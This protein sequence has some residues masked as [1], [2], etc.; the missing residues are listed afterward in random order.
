MFIWWQQYY[1]MMKHNSAR[2]VFLWFR[3]KYKS[4]KFLL[5]YDNNRSNIKFD[6]ETLSYIACKSQENTFP[7]VGICFCRM[8]S[9]LLHYCSKEDTLLF[10]FDCCPFLQSILCILLMMVSWCFNVAKCY[11]MSYFINSQRSASL[12]Y[13]KG[14]TCVTLP[15]PFVLPSLKRTLAPTFTNSGFLMNLP[16]KK[17]FNSEII[18]ETIIYLNL[19]LAWSLLFIPLT[20]KIPS[21]TAVWRMLPMWTVVLKPGTISVGWKRTQTLAWK[22][23]HATGWLLWGLMATI[24]LLS[25]D[26]GMSRARAALCWALTSLHAALFLL[27]LDTWNKSYCYL[28]PNCLLISLTTF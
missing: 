24:P 26:R 27:I 4:K 23:W 21:I 28:S 11:E 18:F 14:K 7:W 1:A 19:T 3:I 12:L 22:Y 9:Y 25:W 16:K 10:R 6:P 8:F 17:S 15:R 2:I 13:S 5:L 20:G